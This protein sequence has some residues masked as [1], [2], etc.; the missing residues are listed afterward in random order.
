MPA[1]S[2]NRGVPLL[3]LFLPRGV[4]QGQ[5][6]VRLRLEVFYFDR[7]DICLSAVFTKFQFTV[8]IRRDPYAI[9]RQ[10]CLLDLFQRKF[11]FR[12]RISWQRTYQ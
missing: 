12:R 7:W 9:I 8:S 5:G 3:S 4:N 11:G 1:G 6:Q 2:G 10:G